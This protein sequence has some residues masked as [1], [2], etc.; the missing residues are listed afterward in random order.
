MKSYEKMKKQEAAAALQEFLDERPH[1]LEHLTRYLAES[2]EGTVNLDGTVESLT[3]LWRWVKS[4]LTERTAETPGPET[5][6]NPTWLRYGIGTEPILSPDS[7]A[8]IDGVISYLCRVVEQGAPKARWRVG[9]NRIKSYMWQNHPVLANDNEE[10]PLPDLVPGLARGQA[11][12]GL[13]SEDDKLTRTAAAVIRRLNGT[14]EDTV[15]EDEPL[16]E[17]EDL[18][19]DELRGRELEVSLRED[20]A[21]EYSREVDGLLKTLVKEEGITGAFREDREVLLVNTPSWN[22]DQLQQWITRYIEDNFR[23][24]KRR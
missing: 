5:S 2:S 21:H 23:R 19:E 14:D 9:Y 10:V 11:S 12:G 4:V 16:I 15:A 17:V 13:T 8:V 7:I 3:P 18:G 24:S 1:A 22:T 6:T 20:I